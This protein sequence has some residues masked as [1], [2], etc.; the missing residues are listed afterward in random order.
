LS[1]RFDDVLVAIGVLMSN[2]IAAW[3]CTFV[4]FGLLPGGRMA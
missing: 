2:L 3:A 4:P 1:N